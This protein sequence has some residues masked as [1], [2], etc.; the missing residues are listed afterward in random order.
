VGK[1]DK[2]AGWETERE[3]CHMS[4]V[5]DYL[6]VAL[7]VTGLGGIVALI[8]LGYVVWS[9]GNSRN[10]AL[11]AG[12]LLGSVILMAVQLLF[13]LRSP[14]TETDNLSTEYTIDQAVPQIR[15]WSYRHSGW[16]IGLEDGAGK[17]LGQTNPELFKNDPE[18]VTKDMTLFSVIGFF[19]WEGNCDAQSSEARHQVRL[20][21]LNQ[22][23]HR[24]N[25]LPSLGRQCWRAYGQREIRLPASV[26]KTTFPI[27]TFVSLRSPRWSSRQTASQ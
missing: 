5:P 13:E 25:A 19:F 23:H 10:L 7:W 24:T 11:G 20:H 15:Q 1:P 14:P 9:N 22:V 4:S 21:I 17:A 2:P 26:V 16:R 18:K 8:C 27:G 3:T 12:A 6:K